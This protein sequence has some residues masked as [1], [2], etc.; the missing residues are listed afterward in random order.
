MSKSWQ[1]KL[2]HSDVQVPPGYR[3]LASPVFRGSTTLFESASDVNDHWDQRASG[4]TYGLYGTPTAL[5]LAG[6]ICELEGGRHT[7][8]A[9]GGQAAIALV[10]FALLQ[11]G[12]HVLIPASIYGPNREL[13]SN[14]LRRFG[15]DATFY[16][17]L[18]GGRIESEIRE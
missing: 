14:M 12:D 15:V 18:L 4:Y 13:T 11:S 17:P 2:L 8:L 16:D 5:E 10:D 1:T 6:R 9:P 3:S 7:I